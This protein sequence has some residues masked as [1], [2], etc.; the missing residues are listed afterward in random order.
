MPCR[1]VQSV[2]LA[3]ALVCTAL[4]VAACNIV[5]PVAYLVEGPAM[6]PAEF[7]LEDR[8]T[9]VF[10]DD[11]ANIVDRAGAVNPRQVRQQIAERASEDLMV[12]ELVTTT[13]SPRDAM[14]Y[15]LRR[16]R[17]EEL[18]PID[19]IGRAVG[20][21]QVIYVEMLSFAV[22]PDGVTPRPSAGVRVRVIDVERRE[23]LFPD[24]STDEVARVVRPVFPAMSMG[25]YQTRATRLAIYEMM[26][27][28]LGSSIAKLFYEHD[29]RELG[30]NLE[31]R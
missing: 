12:E 31:P 5:G 29:P 7:T 9:V 21:A 25:S 18:L 28:E 22:S 11:R 16:D 17:N 15:A 26:A 24:P 4:A 6:V 3:L 19:A 1:P 2:L 14:A 10:I 8:A 30:R 13:I 23:R 27:D 20:A